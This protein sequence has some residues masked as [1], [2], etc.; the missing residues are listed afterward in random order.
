MININNGILLLYCCNDIK[1]HRSKGDAV[2]SNS[3]GSTTLF[4]DVFNDPEQLVLVRFLLCRKTGKQEVTSVLNEV[5]LDNSNFNL[6]NN[7]FSTL[8]LHWT[9]GIALYRTCATPYIFHIFFNLFHTIACVFTLNQLFTS[10]LMISI[11]NSPHHESTSRL[12]F[13][14][15]VH[16]TWTHLSKCY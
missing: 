7:I 8:I 1:S 6:L 4:N 11:I 3:V 12:S 9:V 10:G 14:A 5:L 16:C 13:T 15:N 2:P